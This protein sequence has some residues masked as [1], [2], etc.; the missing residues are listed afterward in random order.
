MAVHTQRPVEGVQ[1]VVASYTTMLIY[2]VVLTLMASFMAWLCN[3]F[4][5]L[6]SIWVRFL[7]YVGYICWAATLGTL[8]PQAWGGSTLAEK[9]DKKLA[10]VLSLVGIFSFVMA[11]ELISS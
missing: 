1:R 5:P 10:N 6:D 9:M 2:G 8:G 7:E 4:F 11:R 3:T